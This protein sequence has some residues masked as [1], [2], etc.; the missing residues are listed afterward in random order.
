MLN[1]STLIA[2]ITF[3]ITTATAPAFADDSSWLAQQ[4]SITDGYSLVAVGADPQLRQGFQA[5]ATNNSS[6]IEQQLS[7]SDGYSAPNGVAG[8]VYVGASLES[9]QDEF[10]QRGQRISDGTTE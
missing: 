1:R 10:V 3:S 4:R 7:I 6:W 8:S 9:S 5:V 2:A